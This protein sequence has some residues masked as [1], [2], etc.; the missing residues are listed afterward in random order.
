MKKQG[1]HSKPRSKSGSKKP[2][3]ATPLNPSAK[4]IPPKA[5]FAVDAALLKTGVVNVRKMVVGPQ[6][7][8]PDDLVNLITAAVSALIRYTYPN[9]E[10]RKDVAEVM[11][12]QFKD[13]L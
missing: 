6:N 9:D 5:A 7:A 12:S 4:V 2:R 10:D 8:D 13:R 3:K 1:K 11:L